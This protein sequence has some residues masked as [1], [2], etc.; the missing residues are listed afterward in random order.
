VK[1]TLIR[2]GPSKA[3]IKSLA[4]KSARKNRGAT[5]VEIEE[6]WKILEES[7]WDMTPSSEEEKDLALSLR[8][9]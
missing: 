7:R 2:K 3:A 1:T 9:N 8:M 5:E 6:Y 4:T